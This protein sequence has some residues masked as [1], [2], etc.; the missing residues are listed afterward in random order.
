MVKQQLVV[1]VENQ[2]PTCVGDYVVGIE[3]EIETKGIGVVMDF[4]ALDVV[5]WINFEALDEMLVKES[6]V[7]NAYAW[8]NSKTLDEDECGYSEGNN[9]WICNEIDYVMT[10]LMMLFS[11]IFL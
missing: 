2:D 11:D 7:L 5:I 4:V 10:V 3:D 6:E 8:K 1:H 9:T